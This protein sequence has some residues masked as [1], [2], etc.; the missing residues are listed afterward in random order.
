MAGFEQHP[1]CSPLVI[2]RYV[3]HLNIAALAST[4]L[5]FFGPFPAFAIRVMLRDGHCQGKRSY[6]GNPASKRKSISHAIFGDTELQSKRKAGENDKGFEQDHRV[7][8]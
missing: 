7:T 6:S 2:F 3:R 4:A 1:L 5:G 8:K